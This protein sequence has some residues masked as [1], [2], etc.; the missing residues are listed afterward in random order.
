M[1]EQPTTTRSLPSVAVIVPVY[2]DWD[3]AVRLCEALTKQTF[4]R[5]RFTITLVNNGD[6]PAPPHHDWPSNAEIVAEAA[7]GSYAARNRGLACSAS[8]IVAFT[9]ADC[10]P[11]PDWLENAVRHLLAGDARVAGRVALTFASERPTPAER[12]EK[13][14][15][16]QQERYVSRGTCVTAN[17]VTWR[18]VFDRVGRF[19]P[20]LLSGGDMQ[21]G[22][23]AYRAGIG[24]AYRSDVVVQHPARRTLRSLLSKRKRTT[25]GDVQFRRPDGWWAIARLVIRRHLPPAKVWRQL[26][27]RPDL[28]PVDRL[29]AINVYWLLRVYGSWQLVLLTSGLRTATRV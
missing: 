13:A 26:T 1:P 29:V 6:S 17:L 21:W 27:R 23:R 18:W 22:M 3:D 12:Y 9:D 24:I 7:P 20:S 28:D 19:D 16:F 8:E 25:G 5:H 15:A 2:H 14:F 11:E 10:V 4:P